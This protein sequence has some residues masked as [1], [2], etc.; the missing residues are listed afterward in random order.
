MFFFPLLKRRQ[1]NC[2]LKLL[3]ICISKKEEKACGPFCSAD[4][5]EFPFATLLV[6]G[7]RNRNIVNFY[8]FLFSFLKLAPQLKSKWWS[9]CSW[10]R[11]SS[12]PLFLRDC[13]DYISSGQAGT[14]PVLP[15]APA[16]GS[17]LKF[18]FQKEGRNHI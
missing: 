9:W 2:P 8:L 13:A 1:K 3:F 16:S 4:H 18:L 17:L 6:L 14:Q 15:W 12:W 10:E 11:G 5:L 7:G